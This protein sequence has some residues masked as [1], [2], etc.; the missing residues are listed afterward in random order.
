MSIY[1]LLWS[2]RNSSS[3]FESKKIILPSR[4][5]SSSLGQFGLRHPLHALL[6]A[7]AVAHML[8]S[9]RHSKLFVNIPDPP[10]CLCALPTLLSLLSHLAC[11]I[12]WNLDT[13]TEDSW[14][15]S[16]RWQSWLIP[17]EEGAGWCPLSFRIPC[18]PCGGQWLFLKVFAEGLGSSLC[19]PSGLT[20]AEGCSGPGRLSFLCP[21]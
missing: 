6:P 12:R 16:T 9:S 11:L 19:S 15:P 21:V 4:W 7:S 14:V 17:S 10:V 8:V 18:V 3:S 13:E 1:Y 2:L 5:N 20:L